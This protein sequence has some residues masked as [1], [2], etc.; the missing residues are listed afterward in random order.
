MVETFLFVRKKETKIFEI[1]IKKKQKSLAP[2]K[3]KL[4]SKQVEKLLSFLFNFHANS[5]NT[6]IAEK[7]LPE[8]EYLR[9]NFPCTNS[10][11]NYLQTC[12]LNAPSF[13]SKVRY[14]WLI[15]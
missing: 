6:L 10:K 7:T 11:D 1:F 8:M 14:F 2:L 4:D 13:F 3:N 5:G 9:K 12:H 15:I